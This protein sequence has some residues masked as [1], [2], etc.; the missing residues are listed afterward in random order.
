MAHI[1]GG[2]KEAAYCYDGLRRW[3]LHQGIDLRW[4]NMDSMGIDD[5]TEDGDYR[6]KPVA[7]TELRAKTVIVQAG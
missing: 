7:F 6:A 4:V 2:V 3:S 1:T 5:E